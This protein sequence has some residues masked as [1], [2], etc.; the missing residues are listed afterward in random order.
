MH[1]LGRLIHRHRRNKNKVVTNNPNEE[2][3][4]GRDFF[5]G[6]YRK[7]IYVPIKFVFVVCLILITFIFLIYKIFHH[8]T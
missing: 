5:S 4:T 2:D 3:R 1:K 6:N 7:K 8:V